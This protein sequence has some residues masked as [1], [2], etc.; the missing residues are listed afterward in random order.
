[1]IEGDG[2]TVKVGN[3]NPDFTLGWTNT[4]SWKGLVLSLLIDGRYGGKVLSQTQADM[5]MY[6][7]TKVTGD[8]RDRGYVM[9]EGEKITNVK[10]FYKSIVGGRSGVTEYYMYDATNFRLRELAILSPSA[11]WRQRSFSGMFNWLLLPEIYFLYTRKRLLT[12]I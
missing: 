6:G 8:A 9:L 10:G 3:A 1:M 4:F 7:V 2:N 11:G 5:D 12:R